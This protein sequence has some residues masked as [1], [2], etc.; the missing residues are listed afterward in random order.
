MIDTAKE[1]A[2]HENCILVLG[3]VMQDPLY[4]TMHT[5]INFKT[6]LL[7]ILNFQQKKYL[8]YLPQSTNDSLSGMAAA[9]AHTTIM[10]RISSLPEEEKSILIAKYE[11]A[12]ASD[13]QIQNNILMMLLR[14]HFE[15]KQAS[16]THLALPGGGV[17]LVSLCFMKCGI[18]ILQWS[19]VDQ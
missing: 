7:A 14:T 4:V 1:I 8:V 16:H 6:I 15:T 12:E 13:T 2:K 17:K 11:G 18:L 3:L 9:K 10:K 5:C 19:L